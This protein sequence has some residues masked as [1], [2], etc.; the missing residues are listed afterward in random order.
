MKSVY[1]FMLF[2]VMLCNIVEINAQS[3]PFLYK[4]VKGYKVISPD[5][6]NLIKMLEMPMNDWRTAMGN[7]EYELDTQR[8]NSE[9]VNMYFIRVL[10]SGYI[11]E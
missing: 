1:A 7:Y 3:A 11:M 5:V 10:G 2:T 6:K 4:E 8:A 9:Y